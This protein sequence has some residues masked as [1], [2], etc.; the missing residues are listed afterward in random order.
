M[1]KLFLGCIFNELF[2][3]WW[4]P[5]VAQCFLLS[6]ADPCHR[7]LTTLEKSSGMPILTLVFNSE[8]FTVVDGVNSESLPL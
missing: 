4:D 8:C 3:S 2:C 1:R 5:E 7:H 6:A